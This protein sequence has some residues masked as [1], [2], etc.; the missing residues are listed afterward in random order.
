MCHD[1]PWTL[2]PR[3]PHSIEEAQSPCFVPFE[4]IWFAFLQ[5]FLYFLSIFLTLKVYNMSLSYQAL[6]QYRAV[7]CV[8]GL[9]MS[10]EADVWTTR[11]AAKVG[12]PYDT[13]LM[14]FWEFYS[15][16]M[17]MFAR[18]PEWYK[19]AYNVALWFFR[20]WNL[21]CH[22]ICG[23]GVS[24]VRSLGISEIMR[25]VQLKSWGQHTRPDLEQPRIFP[26]GINRLGAQKVLQIR[27]LKFMVCS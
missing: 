11:L 18:H 17:P 21:R 24:L 1:H 13:S 12:F 23:T 4:S 6:S 19:V 14:F 16:G 25:A 27:V 2:E 20:P 22:L 5:Q 3:N 7:V 8:S 9:W 26:E 10:R 15:M